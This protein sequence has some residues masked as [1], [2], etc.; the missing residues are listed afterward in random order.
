M[1]N[2]TESPQRADIEI[3]YT[4]SNDILTAIIGESIETFDFTGI[5][6][7]IAEE[8]IVEI[9]TINPIVNVE[10]IGDMVNITVVRFYAE[11]E[12]QLFEVIENE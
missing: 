8:I 3:Q 12:K 11:D 1:I 2:L 9:L 4:I 7:G 10:K 6:E 5:E